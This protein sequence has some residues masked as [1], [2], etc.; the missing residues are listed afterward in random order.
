MIEPLGARGPGSIVGVARGSCA[1]LAFG[2]GSVRSFVAKALGANSNAQISIHGASTAVPLWSTDSS[3]ASEH[4]HTHPRKLPK[5]AIGSTK[6]KVLRSAVRR[7]IKGKGLYTSRPHL[8]IQAFRLIFNP[9]VFRLLRA[10]FALK[11]PSFFFK[12]SE[13]EPESI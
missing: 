1:E 13:Y 12:P 4:V 5:I 9:W 11:E 3:G 2:C 10:I 8:R 7:S 6:A